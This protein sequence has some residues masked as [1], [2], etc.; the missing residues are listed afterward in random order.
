MKKFLKCDPATRLRILAA[1]ATIAVFVLMGTFLVSPAFSYVPLLT[2]ANGTAN[3]DR[4]DFSSFPVSFT[5]N[6]SAG[7]N[8]KGSRSAADVLVASFQTWQTAPNTAIT[9]SRGP[10]SSQTTHGFDGVNLVCFVC[11]AD[12]SKDAST[13]G[14]T[15]TT[16]SDIPG[17]DTKH[18]TKSTFAGQ[19]LDSDIVFNPDIDFSTSG[20]SGQDLQT[21]ATHEIGHFFGL[22]HS[23]IVRATMFPFAPDVETKLSYDDV[24]GISRTYPKSASGVPVGSISG[25]VKFVSGSPVFGAHVFAESTTTAQPYGPTVRKSPIAVLTNP[26]GTYTITGVPAD[27]YTVTAEPLNGP[28]DNSNIEGFSSALGKSAVQ[29]TFNTR[30]H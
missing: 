12:F 15:I 11:K 25:T 20:G 13:L 23:G 14:V 28:M 16:T 21:I 9:I 6:T 4:W 27:Q 5:I 8:I 19:I 26:D 2:R 22:D 24:A 29:T 17:E 1:T 7:D 3:A 10:D 18:G 30:W